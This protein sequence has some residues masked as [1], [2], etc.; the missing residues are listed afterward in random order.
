MVASRIALR[1]PR[2]AVKSMLRRL[3]PAAK[4]MLRRL[5]PAAKS[6]FLRLRHRAASMAAMPPVMAEVMTA[7]TAAAMAEVM[8][9][10]MAAAMAKVITVI[11]SPIDTR[12]GRFAAISRRDHDADAVQRETPRDFSRGVFWPYGPIPCLAMP[13]PTRHAK[14]NL[15][16]SYVGGLTLIRA[17]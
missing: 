9:A 12:S 4:S 3:R 8:T 17:A 11:S 7:L 1:R 13:C 16:P 14:P 10:P 5:H 6:M 15:P 2:L